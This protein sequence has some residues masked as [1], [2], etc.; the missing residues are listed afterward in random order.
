MP[1]GEAMNA[2]LSMPLLSSLK[3]LCGAT[4]YNMSLLSEL[5]ITGTARKNRRAEELPGAFCYRGS[6]T[7]CSLWP[8]VWSSRRTFPTMC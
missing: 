3:S 5:Q 6:L 7:A 4:C 2:R 1:A 8:R